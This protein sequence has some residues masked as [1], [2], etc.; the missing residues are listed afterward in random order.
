MKYGIKTFLLS[1][2]RPQFTAKL[3]ADILEYLILE[4]QATKTYH[5]QAEV[6]TGSYKK[7][8]LAKIVK[9]VGKQQKDLDNY[10]RPL[11]YG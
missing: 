10:V 11:M 4:K 3:L 9:Y 2:K 1:D 7:T 5:L 6:Q 8:F